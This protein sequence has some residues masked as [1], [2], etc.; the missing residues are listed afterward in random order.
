VVLADRDG[1]AATAAAAGIDAERAVGIECDV[2]DEE[3][4]RAAVALA[5]A[6]F[7]KLDV[8]FANAGVFGE[9]A[10]ITEFRREVLEQVLEVNVVGSF[11]LLKHALGAMERGG[12]AIVSS[13]LSVPTLPPHPGMSTHR[14]WQLDR[15]HALRP[16]LDAVR[17]TIR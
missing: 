17:T 1:G 9:V 13:R 10:P 6:R 8:A 2:T 4:V 15:A 7:G 3:Q 12:S 5:V 16:L 14:R 11:L